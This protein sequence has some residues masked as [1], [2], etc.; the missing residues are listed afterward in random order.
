MRTRK[1]E[2]TGTRTDAYDALQMTPR[3]AVSYTKMPTLGSRARTHLTYV[4]DLSCFF[5]FTFCFFFFILISIFLTHGLS[6]S[7]S[8]SALHPSAVTLSTIHTKNCLFLSL[9]FS[10]SFLSLPH[11]LSFHLFYSPWIIIVHVLVLILFFFL[12]INPKPSCSKKPSL[13][14]SS[15]SLLLSFPF[16]FI[17]FPITHRLLCAQTRYYFL[18]PSLKP[19]SLPFLHPSLV[20]RT[21]FLRFPSRF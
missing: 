6:F 20:S 15:S 19:P 12:L 7:L 2:N 17:P 4:H 5:L 10:L 18:Q 13:T 9:L 3:L 1:M 21:R 14:P 8:P 16:F 11:P